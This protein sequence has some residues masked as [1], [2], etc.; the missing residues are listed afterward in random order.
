MQDNQVKQQ[1]YQ[2]K[3][4]GCGASLK[5]DPKSGKLCCAHCGTVVEFDTDNNVVERDFSEMIN[6]D[7]WDESK[8]AFY[9]CENCG[10]SSVLS[11]TT[12]AT[13]CPFCGSPVVVNEK[14]TG[15]V[16]PDSLIPF[17][18]T[19]KQAGEQLSLWQRKR[20]FAPTAFKKSTRADSIKGVFFPT[21]TFDA[22]TKTDYD[23]RL[24]ERKTRTV[25]DSKGNKH[26]ETYIQYFYVKGHIDMDFDDIMVRGSNSIEYKYFTKLQPFDQ[27]KYV[28]YSDE[29]LA[30]YIAD[31]Y[32]VEPL[33]AYAIARK[34]MDSAIE[35]A[36]L[37]KH[38]A[39]VVDYLHLHTNIPTKSFKYM[40]LPVYVSSMKY[41]GK[42]YNQYV[43]GT[44]CDDKRTKAKVAGKAPKS[45]FK[46]A[47]AA[48]LGIAIAVLIVVVA[49]ANNGGI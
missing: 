49:M 35:Q 14:S 39:D 24:G 38:S 44:F 6:F 4:P 41:N 27:S 23:G 8:V 10:A 11:R 25:S 28:V 5:F 43:A 30:G 32:S 34:Q 13:T 7:A 12:L 46:I 33:D 15:L 29:Y 26:T 36:I 16:R 3:C 20:I 9:R 1:A 2:R 48:L 45:P 19:A 18:L 17:E 22:Q 31:N 42:L 21:W 40:M 47:L 37:R